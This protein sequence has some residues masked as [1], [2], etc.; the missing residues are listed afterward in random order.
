[1]VPFVI[2]PD[3]LLKLRL[4]VARH[5][6]MDK[7]GWWNTNG[8]L[9]GYGALALSRGLPTTHRFARARVV[10]H[11][12]RSRCEELFHAPGSATLWHLPAE[13]E[14]QFDERWQAWLKDGNAWNPFFDEL[15]ATEDADLVSE[16][17]DRGLLSDAH[18]ETIQSL[19]RSA[20]GRAVPLHSEHRVDDDLVTLL[21]GGFSKG[22]KG[23]PAVPYARLA[24]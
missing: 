23:A 15:A 2:D 17:R 24:G 4:V 6:E 9:G 8:M 1:V 12:A 19:R 13:I 20:E 11:V 5:G 14:D 21:A 7:A 22:E 3:R 10:F 18:S 16:L